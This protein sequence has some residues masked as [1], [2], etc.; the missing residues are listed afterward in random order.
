M[1][2][3]CLDF[4]LLGVQPHLY[5]V[6]LVDFVIEDLS[7][8]PISRIWWA[9]GFPAPGIWIPPYFLWWTQ[10]ML[11]SVACVLDTLTRFASFWASGSS[12]E[13]GGTQYPAC[14]LGRIGEGAG[15]EKGIGESQ[16]EAHPQS[17]S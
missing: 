16:G 9:W 7:S 14:V 4:Y 6:F 15:E 5:H 2:G 3:R 17:F 1:V 11:Y 8:S 12:L 10:D 13:Y